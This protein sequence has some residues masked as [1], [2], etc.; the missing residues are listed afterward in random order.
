M[1]YL[2][3]SDI[4]ANI[5]ALDAVLENAGDFDKIWCLGDVVG[6]G[7]NPNECIERLQEF[8][9]VCVAGNHDWAAIER[10]DLN[11]FNNDAQTA[12]L[13]TKEQLTDDSVAYLEGL[14]QKHVQDGVT[15]VHGSPREPVW[16]Y[17][18]F[19]GIAKTQFAHFDTAVCFV[20]HT[21]APVIFSYYQSRKGPEVCETSVLPIEE[22]IVVGEERQIINPGSV[23]Q[24][25]DGDSRAAYA[26]FDT[27]SREFEHF[28][29]EYSI[30]QVQEAMRE[31]DLPSRLIARLAYGW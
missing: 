16:E 30:K 28:R 4:H 17:I 18:L 21:H 8:S 6:Y 13:W 24:P 25:R 1:R 10:L 14:P 20:G 5:H 12:T 7:P 11:D 15:F 9:H 19:P 31:Q 29:V 26:I 2:V 23:G 3:V 27:E 22:K